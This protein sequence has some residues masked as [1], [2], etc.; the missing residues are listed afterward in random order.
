MASIIPSRLGRRKQRGQSMLEFALTL[1]LLLF[2]IM[3][4]F[5]FSRALFTYV[6]ASN[7][8]RDAL[9]Y[10]AILGVETNPPQYVRCAD[11]I[12]IADN[13]SFAVT[14]PPAPS[15]QA[16]NI[17]I[18]YYNTDGALVKTAECQTN[19]DVGPNEIQNGYSLEIKV[20]A[21]VQMITPFFPQSVPIVLEGR[22]TIV[23]NLVL[24]DLAF[25]GDG[26]CDVLTEEGSCLA[27]CCGNT[28]PFQV[29]AGPEENTATCAVDCPA[30]AMTKP[31]LLKTSPE[32]PNA[33]PLP[34]IQDILRM[35]LWVYDAQDVPLNKPLTVKLT[36]PDSTTCNA[37][38]MAYVSTTEQIFRSCDWN[39]DSYG[40]TG[41]QSVTIKVE[42]SDSHVA[43][44]GPT[45]V[46]LTVWID[47]SVP[48]SPP[49]VT[50][51][52]PVALPVETISGIYILKATVDDDEPI[53]SNAVLF[54][55]DTGVVICIGGVTY[56]F[57]TTK[58]FECRWDSTGY[59]LSGPEPHNFEVEV[60]DADG[61]TDTDGP[62]L[63]N[64]VNTGP[65]PA[66]TPPTIAFNRPVDTS[67][68]SG[69]AY[70]IRVVVGDAEDAVGSLAGNIQILINGI[71]SCTPFNNVIIP[72]ATPT[73]TYECVWNSTVMGA[74]GTYNDVPFTATVTD[75]GGLSATATVNPNVFVG[76][77]TT[78]CWDY[79]CEAPDESI[80]N[81]WIDCGTETYF[82]VG[83]T[84]CTLPNQLRYPGF[85]WDPVPG[86]ATFRLYAQ[87]TATSCNPQFS[88]TLISTW[89]S[90]VTSCT[91][92][93]GNGKPTCFRADY[94]K[95]WPNNVNEPIEYY[96]RVVD[97]GGFEGVINYL[98]NNGS[99]FFQCGN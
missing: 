62:V 61:L 97:S 25:C 74:S 10:G 69:T 43:L 95:W 83:Q 8:V 18:F 38:K 34:P 64:V 77:G 85:T 19:S 87:C 36:F 33:A 2:T 45:V 44:T 82:R 30:S 47:N 23:K 31:V 68:V 73:T 32:F 12:G 49:T 22:R 6:Q 3:A 59:G 66:N 58:T 71:H 13:I 65:L 55:M 37:T 41:P 76:T 78:Q 50:L 57:T 53:D 40:K 86:A 15:T 98:D 96:L 79:I 56:D 39:T 80:A 70:V 7:A 48:P 35:D 89:P 17:D 94:N 28:F 46:N 4:L 29:C 16:L 91:G 52:A 90:S 72:P 54:K 93:D 99:S 63:A 27:D 9:R 92:L 1:P 84:Q 51:T 42:I 5:D 14:S 24:E 21:W 67:T 11:M 88:W 75:S 81:C 26:F 60:I 20:N